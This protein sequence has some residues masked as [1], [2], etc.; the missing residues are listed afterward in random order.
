MGLQMQRIL[1]AAGQQ[2]P[3]PKPILELNPTHPLIVSLNQEQD[4]EKLGEWSTLL[5]GQSVL[6]EGGH[7]DDPAQFVQQMNKLLLRG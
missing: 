7:L 4:K 5:L 1:Q 2:V 6:A 3:Q